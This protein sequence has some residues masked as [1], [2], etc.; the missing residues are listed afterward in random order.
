MVY[1]VINNGTTAELKFYGYIS[2]WWNG[3]DDYTRTLA[4][5]EGKGIKNVVVR[6]HCYGGSVMEGFAIWTAN[7]SSKLNIEFVIDGIAASMMAIVMLSG[8]KVTMSSVAKVMVHAP[9]DNQGGVSK[10]LFQTAKLLK[11]MEKDFINVWV[12]KTKQTTA[13]AA[14]YMDGTDYWL[15]A[16]ECKKLGVCDAILTETVFVTD[17]AAKPDN[18]TP[19]ENIYNRYTAVASQQIT[20]NQNLQ[21]MD[22]KQV[23]AK[24]GLIGVDENSSETAIYDAIEAKNTAAV[25]AATVGGFKAQAK[26]MIAAKETAMGTKFTAE[27]IA[28]FEA[29]ATNEAGIKSLETVLAAMQ[30][31]PNITNMLANEGKSLGGSPVAADRASWS[32]DKWEKED[33]TGLEALEKS[34]IEAFAKLYNAKFPKNEAKFS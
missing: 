30:P 23:I 26:T 1:K 10:Q 32:W 16:E 28:S 11:S 22:K 21:K 31:V 25:N 29:L 34:N 4:E 9:R 2:S 27:Q 24:F 5:I 12:A 8:K 18:G 15:D 20:H 19:I 13:Q 3:A 14:V 17:I 7:K 33:P 6:T